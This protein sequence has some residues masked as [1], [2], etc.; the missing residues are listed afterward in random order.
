MKHY[1]LE[2]TYKK[3]LVELYTFKRPLSDLVEGHEN[4][5][6]ILVKEIGWRWGDF[7]ID[8]PETEA[9]VKEWLGSPQAGLAA[10]R[11]VSIV[12]L[13]K[14]LPSPWPGNNLACRVHSP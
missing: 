2:P 12:S 8:V 3:S 14:V 13:K 1:K 4:R 6:A 10:F 7:T 11:L 9:E 5:N